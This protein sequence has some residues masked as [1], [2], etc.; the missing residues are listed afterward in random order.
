ME[1]QIASAELEA[2]FSS[3]RELGCAKIAVSTHGLEDISLTSTY[4]EQKISL[5]FEDI[6]IQDLMTKLKATAWNLYS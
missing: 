3:C 5:S 4:L 1:G 2:A 6:K